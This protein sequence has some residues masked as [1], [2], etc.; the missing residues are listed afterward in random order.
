MLVPV[1]VPHFTCKMTQSLRF[2]DRINA[3]VL[4][5]GTALDNNRC[6]QEHLMFGDCMPQVAKVPQIAKNTNFSKFL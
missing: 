5:A 3:L 4:P 1:V 2:I 6:M